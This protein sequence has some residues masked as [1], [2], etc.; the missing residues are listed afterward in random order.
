MQS[1]EIVSGYAAH[2]TFLNCILE[3]LI[4]SCHRLTALTAGHKLK[5]NACRAENVACISVYTYIRNGQ[6]TARQ[7]TVS[8]DLLTRCLLDMIKLALLP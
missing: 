3:D 5:H 4:T 2:D 1:Y 6:V 8:Q 7:A